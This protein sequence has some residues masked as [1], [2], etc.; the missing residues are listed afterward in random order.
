MDKNE[1]V[2]S[3]IANAVPFHAAPNCRS[4]PK[5]AVAALAGN[6][7]GDWEGAF[8]EWRSLLKTPHQRLADTQEFRGDL[9]RK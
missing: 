7:R 4:L 8:G 5:T 6:K 1:T 3:D 2:A 9:R